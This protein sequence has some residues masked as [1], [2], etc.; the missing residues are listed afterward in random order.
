MF[1]MLL[2][3]VLANGGR[4]PTTSTAT[5]NVSCDPCTGGEAITF[6]G[7]GYKSGSKVELD[8]QGPS[9][10]S[11]VVTVDSSGNISVNYGSALT[12]ASGGY[13]ATTSAISGKR[14][15]PQASASFS[16]Q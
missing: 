13:L 3:T 16:V 5:L 1:P 9:S 12:F 8:I 7:T 14:L 11:I 4:Q 15:I 10:Y 2:F 6:Y